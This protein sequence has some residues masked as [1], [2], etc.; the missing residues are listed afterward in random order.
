MRRGLLHPLIGAGWAFAIGYFLGVRVPWTLV[1]LAFAGFTAQVTLRELWRPTGRRL[2]AHGEGIVQALVE[3]Q[4][5]RGQRR[6]GAYIA[7]AG[8]VIIICAI[9]VSSTMGTSKEVQLR[10][11][12]SVTLGRYALAFQK[13]ETV[14]EPHR[15]IV[16]ARIAVT[17]DGRDLGVLSPGMTYY[18]TQREPVGTPDVHTSLFEDLYLSVMNIDPAASTIGLHALVNPMVAWIWAAA[19]VM[20]L[21]GL[22]ALL[23]AR[24]APERAPSSVVAAAPQAAR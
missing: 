15:E 22:V 12:E 13:V 24:R 14:Q 2:A 20:A 10:A 21:G 1:T 5:R 4:V 6:L 11:G 23:P 9:A 16:V 19:A 17:R 3:S 18:E 7:H 8:A